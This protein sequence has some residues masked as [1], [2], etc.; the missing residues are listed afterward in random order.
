MKE[1]S[2]MWCVTACTWN[3]GFADVALLQDV[4]ISTAAVVCPG[5]VFTQ[6][7]TDPPDLTVII[8]WTTEQAVFL[9]KIYE[10]CDYSAVESLKLKQKWWRPMDSNYI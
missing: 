10:M 4:S 9:E 8:V 5:T 7:V 1:Q 2:T 6:L 3:I